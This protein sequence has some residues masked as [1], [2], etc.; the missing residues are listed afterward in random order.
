MAVSPS[1]ESSI[2]LMDPRMEAMVAWEAVSGFRQYRDRQVYTSWH[3]EALSKLGE[4]SAAKARVRE[5]EKARMFA[6]K[7]PSE[8]WSG[9][10]AEAILYP[11]KSRD[12]ER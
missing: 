7:F 9:R 11:R 1:Y 4:A 2:F 5:E 8:Q 3:D 10:S 12:F 6:Y